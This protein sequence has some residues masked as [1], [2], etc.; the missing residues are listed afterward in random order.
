MAEDG[1]GNSKTKNQKG[2][3][4]GLSSVAE[5]GPRIKKV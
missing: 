1:P 3:R 4:G 5:H 2:D